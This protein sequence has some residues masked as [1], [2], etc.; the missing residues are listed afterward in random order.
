MQSVFKF[1]IGLYVL[2]QVDKGLFALDHKIL[3]KKTDLMPNSWSPIRDKYPDGAELTLA[4]IIK[5]TVSQSDNSGCDILLKLVG[6]PKAVHNY[7]HKEGFQDVSIVATEE[8]M[9]KDWDVQF[10]N[11]TTPN[12]ASA[13]LKSF[14]DGKLL[15]KASNDF[16]MKA[17]TETIT[18]KKNSRAITPW[19]DSSSQDR[20][21]RKK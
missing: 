10:L 20:Q 19:N 2:S 8:E 4:E 14:F 13:V 18:G 12:C 11:W 3:I 7:F 9:H 1:H 21:F 15:S 16:L 5:F 6:G 17:M